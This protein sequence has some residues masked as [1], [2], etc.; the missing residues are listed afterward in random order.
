[1]RVKIA[2]A[3]AL[4]A[5]L[6][7]ARVAAQTRPCVVSIGRNATTTGSDSRMSVENTG[8]SCGASMFVRPETQTPTST[9]TL[10]MPPAHGAVVITQPNRFDYTPTAGFS[11]TDSF[12]LTGQPAPFR[13]I[14]SVT[15]T[16]P[17]RRR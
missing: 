14:M 8:H 10:A 15:V 13:V 1:M 6:P 7:A 16:P 3:A 2:L 9:L 11:G 17:Q 12:V 4:L 5:L